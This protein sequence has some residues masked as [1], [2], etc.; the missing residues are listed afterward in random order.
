VGGSEL[1]IGSVT[2]ICENY[3]VP[4]EFVAVTV[5]AFGTS[6][7]ELVTAIAA[8]IKGHA[9]L[10]VGNIIGAD[11]LNVLFVIGASASAGGLDV[12]PSFLWLYLPMMMV[13]LIMLRLFIFMPGK[14]FSRWQ[15]VPLLA[16]YVIF[17]VLTIKFGLTSS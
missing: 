14:R 2:Q 8:L 13:V 3:G 11:I 9:D 16:S 12:K 15:G 5:V 7:P 6:L 4:E 1:L 10:L 17:Y